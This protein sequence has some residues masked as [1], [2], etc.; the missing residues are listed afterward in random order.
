MLYLLVRREVLNVDVAQ[1]KTI[2]RLLVC[3]FVRRNLT[4][5]P[6]TRDLTRLFMAIIDKV[7]A[8]SG[9]AVVTSIRDELLAVS[10]S[11]ETF[12]STLVGAI[13]E[14]NAGVTRFVLCAW[15]E[16][17]MTTE[18]RVEWWED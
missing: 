8:L 13:Y 12:R 16:Q 14:E 3:F 6:H 15:A 5:T 4:D 18:T 11:D 17:R 7:A 10:A 9:D 2:A 1:L